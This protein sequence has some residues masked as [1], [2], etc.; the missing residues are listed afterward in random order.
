MRPIREFLTI[1][2]LALLVRAAPAAAPD[3]P[4]AWLPAETA[5]VVRFQSLERL[6][7]NFKETASTLG[8]LANPAVE[9]VEQGLSKIFRVEADGT[10]IDRTSPAYLGAFAIEGQPEAVVWM[11]KSADEAKLRRT[12]L[13]VGAEETLP[14]EKAEGGFEKVM[15]DGR[16]WFFARR[17]EWSLYTRLPEVVKALAFNAEQQPTIAKLFAGRAADL[18]ADGDAAIMVNVAH[19]LEVYSDKVDELHDKLRRQIESLPKEFLGGDSS[20]VDPRATKKMYTDLA[21]L[22][23]RSVGDAQWAAARLNFTAAGV[24]LAIELGVKGDT[25]TDRLLIANPPQTLETLSLLPKNAA[26]YFAHTSGSSGLVDWYRDWLKLAYGEDTDA[27][28]MLARALETMAAAGQ[29]S[30]ATSF[31]FP[32]GQDTSITTVSLTQ[33]DDPEKYRSATTVYEPTANRQQTALFS[34]SV[35]VQGGAEEYQGHSVDLLTT[36]VK[37][38]DVAD[39][40]QAIGQKVLEKMFGGTELQ[41]RLTTLE[42]MV[43][44]AAGNDAKYLHAAVDGLQ[45]GE[46]VLGLDDAF[47]ATRDQ[48]AEKANMVGLINVPRMVID[49][50]S[51]VRTVPPLDVALAQAPINLGAQPATSYAGVSLATAPQALRLDVFVPVSQPKGV[52]QIFG[53]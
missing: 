5:A 40:G 1:L 32:S 25:A 3:D 47:A 15:K 51:L 43:V 35:E 48:L 30:S 37:F 52:L 53:Q 12:V 13:G 2:L 21:D 17:G 46:N 22:A 7:N 36:R 45:N 27:S 38:T 31:S 49:L 18:A 20:A 10:V 26:V 50:I 14:A 39:P 6:A 16:V 8:P 24:R 19:L 28:K 34:Q 29:H 44:Q 42:G 41:T 9:G 33:A 11:V 4:L 23:F